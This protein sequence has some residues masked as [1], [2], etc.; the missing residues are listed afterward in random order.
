MELAGDILNDHW[1]KQVLTTIVVN[2]CTTVLHPKDFSRGFS[3]LAK[4]TSMLQKLQR[5]Q[6]STHH[7]LLASLFIPLPTHAILSQWKRAKGT[8]TQTLLEAW[9]L[10]YSRPRVTSKHPMDFLRNDVSPRQPPLALPPLPRPQHRR[11]YRTSPLPSTR[12]HPSTTQREDHRSTKLKLC[13]S[14]NTK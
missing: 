13:K 12:R 8:Q 9:K 14:I 6:Y 3:W 10:P 1:S 11:H 5:K 4:L 2:S 7:Q